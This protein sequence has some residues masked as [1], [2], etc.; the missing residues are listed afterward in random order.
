MRRSRLEDVTTGA[1]TGRTHGCTDQCCKREE[2][3]CQLGAV[4]TWHLADNPVA[5]AFVRFWTKADK[6]GFWPAMVCPLM[7]HSGHPL[8]RLTQVNAAG[9]PYAAAYCVLHGRVENNLD[10]PL[11]NACDSESTAGCNKIK[12]TCSKLS[13][14]HACS[15]A[16]GFSLHGRSVCRAKPSNNCIHVHRQ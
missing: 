1:S 13:V 5:P 2:S 8:R 3:P 4:H 9:R 7:T 16:C 10:T 11:C 14:C 15:L 6:G 12:S